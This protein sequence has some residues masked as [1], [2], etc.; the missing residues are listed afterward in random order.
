MEEALRDVQ[1]D[2]SYLMNQQNCNLVRDM[3]LDLH[4]MSIDMQVHPVFENFTEIR[5]P[6]GAYPAALISGKMLVEVYKELQKVYTVQLD[7]FPTDNYPGAQFR[8]RSKA[9][10]EAAKVLD[11]KRTKAASDTARKKRII[12]QHRVIAQLYGE[13]A[14]TCVT[15]D[16]L[17]ALVAIGAGE[18]R[19]TLDAP[20]H[21]VERI[22]RETLREMIGDTFVMAMR[23]CPSDYRH[24]A[25]PIATAPL[26]G[27]HQETTLSIISGGYNSTAHTLGCPEVLMAIVGGGLLEAQCAYI[28][29]KYPQ[30][31]GMK[32]DTFQQLNVPSEC[33]F[34]DEERSTT[35]LAY[36][37]G[38]QLVITGNMMQKFQESF[39]TLLIDASC[40]LAEVVTQ[41]KAISQIG[42]LAMQFIDWVIARFTANQQIDESRNMATFGSHMVGLQDQVKALLHTQVT[43]RKSEAIKELCRINEGIANTRRML[44]LE[45]ATHDSAKALVTKLE[46]KD[47][48]EVISKDCYDAL[49]NNTLL[50]YVAISGIEVIFATKPLI[51]QDL[52]GKCVK[53]Q[54]DASKFDKDQEAW[55]YLGGFLVRGYFEPCN[56]NRKPLITRI[57]GTRIDT[58]GSMMHAPHVDSSGSPCLGDAQPRMSKAIRNGDLVEYISTILD[59]LLSVNTSDAWGCRVVYWPEATEAQYKKFWADRTGKNGALLHILKG[60]QSVTL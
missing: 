29:G 27:T 15:S 4:V 8:L 39:G 30:M 49:L 48:L 6:H 20:A 36:M 59:Y 34:V 25:G 45:Y 53:K 33:L 51:V 31:Y 5:G 32:L 38:H 13:S 2:N 16:G 19:P 54:A 44:Q 1:E 7:I 17:T 24:G 47:S 9:E 22:L 57:E 14:R 50:Q 40:A 37:I 12:E 43:G 55:Y 58:R 41:V 11:D 60:E 52:R 23:R 46:G 21:A 28:M 42:E 56:S 26:V 18:Y 10:E 3:G 35:V